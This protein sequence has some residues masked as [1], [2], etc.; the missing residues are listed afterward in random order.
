[1]PELTEPK[2]D[3]FV[4]FETVFAAYPDKMQNEDNQ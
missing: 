4:S 2:C 3:D 1:M